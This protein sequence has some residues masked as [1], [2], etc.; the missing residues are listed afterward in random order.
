M[1]SSGSRTEDSA[2]RQPP[3]RIEPKQADGCR[4]DRGKWLDSMAAQFEVISPAM[5]AAVKQRHNFK[6]LGVDGADVAAFP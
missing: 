5:T 6:G 4:S 3:I 2:L 1:F